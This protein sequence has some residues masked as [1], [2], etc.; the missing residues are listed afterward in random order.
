MIEG[1]VWLHARMAAGMLVV[2]DVQVLLL[3]E[4]AILI[5]W[6]TMLLA[7]ILI[8][9]LHPDVVLKTAFHLFCAITVMG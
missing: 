9:G 7:L 6:I 8:A 4:T 2:I 5:S 3:G 1:V